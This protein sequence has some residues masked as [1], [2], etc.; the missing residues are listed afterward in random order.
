MAIAN[1]RRRRIMAIMP[2]TMGCYREIIQGFSI[3][4]NNQGNWNLELCLPNY[5][6]LRVIKDRKPDGVFLGPLQDNSKVPAVLRASPRVIG[7]CGGHSYAGFKLNCLECDDRAVGAMAA[8]ALLEKGYRNYAFVGHVGSCWSD[9]RREAFH[10]EITRAGFKCET[11]HLSF[12]FGIS[13][14]DPRVYREEN[15]ESW[16]ARLPKPIAIMSYNDGIGATVARCCLETDVRVPD[17]VSI[18]GVDNDDLTTVIANP[19]LSSVT[20]PW[21]EMGQLASALMDRLL[22]SEKIATT[23]QLVPPTGIAERQSTG[24]TAIDD[25]HVRAAVRFIREARRCS[26]HR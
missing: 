20:L 17:E 19:P 22:R 14:Q 11:Y 25:E 4:A 5:D 23:T 10:A 6:F 24:A 18:L 3:Y 2:T 13:W 1:N 12:S 21:R 7:V 26:N 9:I 16:I 15:L 8:K